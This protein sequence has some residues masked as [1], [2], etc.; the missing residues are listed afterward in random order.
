MLQMLIL[1]G[2]TCVAE[3]KAWRMDY[4]NKRFYEGEFENDYITGTGIY[5]FDD[6]RKYIGQFVNDNKHGIGNEKWNNEI[7]L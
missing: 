1:E 3:R 4:G 2:L 6:G 5:N 7:C